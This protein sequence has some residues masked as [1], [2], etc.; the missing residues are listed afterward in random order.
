MTTLGWQVALLRSLPSP[1][2]Y[3]LTETHERDTTTKEINLWEN[4]VKPRHLL[5]FA[6]SMTTEKTFNSMLKKKQDFNRSDRHVYFYTVRGEA[7]PSSAWDQRLPSPFFWLATSWKQKVWTAEI[8]LCDIVL[9]QELKKSLKPE[10]L[11]HRIT[12]TY[13]DLVKRNLELVSAMDL[14][15]RFLM[16]HLEDKTR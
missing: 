7:C 13:T 10:I 2:V 9:I 1:C 4:S 12:C 14:L 5:Y 6:P 11:S 15:K 16:E 3:P 8:S